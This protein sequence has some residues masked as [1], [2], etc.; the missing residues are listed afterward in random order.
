M[1]RQATRLGVALLAATALALGAPWASA[2]PQA[3]AT[4]AAAPDIDVA[5]VKGHLDQLQSIATA[6]GGNRATGS[7][8]HA[9][10]AAY[11]KQQ[12][13]AAGF[14]VTS[15]SCTSCT[16][17]APN[18]IADW[19]GGDANQ[20]VMFGAHLDGVSAGPGIN[21]DGSGSSALLEVALTLG[22]TKPVLAKHVR[23]AWWAGEEQGLVGSRFY[24]NGLSS[25]ERAKIKVYSTFDMIASPNAGYFVN[26][27][28]DSATALRNY[29]ASI[30]VAVETTN[31][32]CSD[33]G[34]FRNAGIP[35][36]LASTGA[37]A[38]KTSAQAAK[39]GGTAGAAYD[40]CYHRACDRFPSN[41]NDVALDRFSDAIA[42]AVWKLGVG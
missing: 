27:T 28:N 35:V 29:F 41:I 42:S 7:Q 25:A 18:V 8:G 12:L 23:F 6:N 4:T 40:S 32:C 33:D 22:R 3:P 26:G 5:K 20:V 14:T 34:S 21:D 24:V 2:A 38:R 17:Q 11:V 9:K 39:W 16:G 19:P 13:Q 37:S 31:E 36:V 15:Q 10:S 30:N 1:K